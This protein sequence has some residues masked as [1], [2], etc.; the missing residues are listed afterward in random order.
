MWPW[1]IKLGSFDFAAHTSFVGKLILTGTVYNEFKALSKQ[2]HCESFSW[3]CREITNMLR[4]EVPR[5][6]NHGCGC[7]GL[8]WAWKSAFIPVLSP[9]VPGGWPQ[10]RFLAAWGPVSL[11]MDGDNQVHMH[12]CYKGWQEYLWSVFRESNTIT[13][14]RTWGS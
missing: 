13:T 2:R 14:V 7:P 11:F 6:W 8:T 12:G 10:A 3:F 4:V 1:V 5:T 9:P